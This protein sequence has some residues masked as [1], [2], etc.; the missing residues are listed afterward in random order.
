MSKEKRTYILITREFPPGQRGGIAQWAYNLHRTLRDAGHD[1][2]VLTRKK[3][4]K[5]IDILNSPNSVKYISGRNWEKLSWIYLLPYVLP[6]LIANRNVSII[7]ATWN[8]IKVLRYL[9]NFFRFTLYCSARG[10]E[11]TNTTH[12]W[13][14]SKKSALRR[15]L[16]DVDYLLPISRFLES[17]IIASFPDL[18]LKS[19]IIGNDVDHKLFVPLV[20]REK[21]KE[22]RKL[23]DLPEN[24][25]IVLSVGRMVEFKGYPNL[26][27]AFS[28]VV[29]AIPETL[30]IIVSDPK[31]PEYGKVLNVIKQNSLERHVKLLP[32]VEQNKLPPV[33]QLADVFVLYSKKIVDGMHQEEGFGKTSIEAAACGLPVIVSNTGGQPETIIHGKT[34]YVVPSGDFV[35]LQSAMI[36]LLSDVQ[37]AETM[38]ANGRK[39]IE[40]RFTSEIMRDKILAL[41]VND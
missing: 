39:F 20:D 11:I 7:S 28:E 37:L 25:K 2:T 36:Q 32:S 13:A 29:K 14:G 9:K 4:K 6:V 18:D 31:E 41:P 17:K 40:E 21:K 1:I 23:H 19:I 24:A 35:K 8:E 27:A 38:G 5:D 34:G 15:V 26:I 30:F 12:E 3:G 22:L 10:T 33:Y 16:K